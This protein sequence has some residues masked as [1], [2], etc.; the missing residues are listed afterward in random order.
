MNT[1]NLKT[2]SIFLSIVG[3]GLWYLLNPSSITT[4]YP[5]KPHSPN[6]NPMVHQDLKASPRN[7]QPLQSPEL[8][9][10]PPLPSAARVAP[11]SL[12]EAPAPSV[13]P[14]KNPS[15][16]DSI[17]FK[18]Y[19]GLAIAYGDVLL[20]RLQ[21][22]IPQGFTDI[23]K[24]NYWPSSTIPY[25]V[26]PNVPNPERIFKALSYLSEKTV[27]EFVPIEE[28]TQDAIVFETTMDH[29]FS[30]V[31]R[32][33]GPQPL[34]ISDG[35]EW[36]NIAHEVLHALGFMH[37]HSRPDRDQ[38]ISIQW[39]AI[40]E[41]F[42][43]QFAIWPEELVQSWLNYSYDIKSIMHYPSQSLKPG[44]TTPSLLRADGS[45]LQPNKE[46]SPLD[47]QKVND[48]FKGRSGM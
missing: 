17:P 42:Q 16:K 1:N 37:E 6:L 40:P 43:S 35:C 20:G 19:K 48:L 27:L 26:Q 32:V 38:Y 24:V 5:R 7:P 31:G 11:P 47:V 18:N 33:T 3:I 23:P 12:D 30:Y 36:F 8:R 34:Y 9:S 46:L 14:R 22:N 29:C 2:K 41:E 28:G 39:N 4:E 10:S 44:S 13:R 25:Y 15:P 21:E 45:F